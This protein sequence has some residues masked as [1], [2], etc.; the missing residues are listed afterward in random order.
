MVTRLKRWYAQIPRDFFSKGRNHIMASHSS[1]TSRGKRR[2]FAPRL[3]MMEDRQLLN[4]AVPGVTLDPLTV[5]KFANAL[6]IPGVFQPTT[7]GGNNYDIG[8]YQTQQNLLGTDTLG[9]TFPDTTVWGYVNNDSNAH[10]PATYPGHSFEV[11]ANQ[12]IFV[13]W[14]NNLVDGSGNPLPHL[15][16]VDTTVLDPTY[17]KSSDPNNPLQAGVPIVTHVHGGHTE[18][19]SDGTPLQWFTPNPSGNPL[20]TGADYVTNNFTYPN[21]QQAAT[22]WYHDHAMGVTRLNVYAG[23]AGF[24]I[25]HDA[26]ENALVANHILPEK[27]YDIPLAIQDRMFTVGGQLYYPANPL[28]PQSPDPSVH[29]EFFGDTILV[30]GKAWPFLNVEPRMYRFRIVNGSNSRFY[31]LFLD[32]GQPIMQIGTDDGLLAQPVAL[33]HLTIAPGKRADVVIDFSKLAGQTIILR[34]NAKGPF[35]HGALPSRRRPAR[36]WSFG[37]ASLSRRSRTRP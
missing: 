8:V 36:S 29:P 14:T 27:P 22:I 23:L 12:P 31:D 28:T 33:S 16:P 21:T 19:A 34:N 2:R 6:P 17:P 32:S 30:N 25:I 18:A 4:A 9:N 35:P 11:Q 13:H 20:Y 37:W 7:P 5:Q 10:Q 26:N 24:Y 3:E 15:L 1:A